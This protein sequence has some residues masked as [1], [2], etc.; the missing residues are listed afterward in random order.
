M[1]I[2]VYFRPNGGNISP[3]SVLAISVLEPPIFWAAPGPEVRVPGA[4]SGS[5]QKKAAPAPYT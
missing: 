1:Q 3:D 2:L 5:R 4:D